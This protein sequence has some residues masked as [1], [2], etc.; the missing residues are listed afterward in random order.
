M[1]GVLENSLFETQPHKFEHLNELTRQFAT[2]YCGNSIVKDNIFAVI[3]NYARKKEIPLEILRFPIIGIHHQNYQS[4]YKGK[5]APSDT[6]MTARKRLEEKRPNTFIGRSFGVGDVI[7]WDEEKGRKFFYVDKEELVEFGG[8]MDA[9]AAGNTV[10]YMVPNYQIDGKTGT[11]LPYDSEVVEGVCFFM[12]R[13]EQRKD[14]ISPV[15]VDS[16]GV[17]VTDAPNGFENV[18]STLTEYVQRAEKKQQDMTEYEKCLTNGTYERARE[19]GT[20][21]NYDMIDGYVNNVP[22]KPRRIGGRWSV[23]DRLH[24]K[25]A[26]RKQK[27]QTQQQQQER[28]RKN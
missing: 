20:E 8:F 28:S 15:V 18:R 11:W 4:A 6:P 3:E 25:Q 1:K 26:Q 27:D 2:I 19:S 23:L 13:N 16:K 24:I 17:F 5:P 21:Q 12:M 7:V 14:A 10:I 22:K 9:D